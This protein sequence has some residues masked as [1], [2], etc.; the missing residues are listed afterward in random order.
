M[1]WKS[2]RL[3]AGKLRHRCD[4]VKPSPVQDST[5]GINLS[6]DILYANVWCSIEALDGTETFAANTQTSASTHQCIIRYISG[7]PGYQVGALYAAG[8]LIKDNAG[9]LQQCQAPG[10]VAVI[11]AD[12]SWNEIEGMYTED[13]NPSVGSFTWYNLGP[14]PLYTGI[15]SAMQIVFQGRQ[16]QITSVLNPDERNKMLCLLMTEINQSRQ[17]SPNVSSADLG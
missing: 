12:N 2:G 11:T 17:Q 15:T 4:I 1:N 5:G 10:G 8:Q 7:A 14:A 13:G 16:F 3:A 6:S 9:Y